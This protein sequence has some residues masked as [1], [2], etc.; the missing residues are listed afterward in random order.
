M[1][2]DSHPLR[3]T[4]TQT[5]RP[6]Q[7]GSNLQNSPFGWKKVARFVRTLCRLGQDGGTG[8]DCS[9][10]ELRVLAHISGDPHEAGL[11]GGVGHPCG[12]CTTGL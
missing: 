4:L 5:G 12:D 9:Q 11:L 10:I 2:R 6:S 8:T 7:R 3:Q 1:A